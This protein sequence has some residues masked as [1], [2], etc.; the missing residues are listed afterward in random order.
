MQA[1]RIRKD[2]GDHGLKLEYLVLQQ[3]IL[4]F[5]FVSIFTLGALILLYAAPRG[6]YIQRLLNGVTLPISG[7]M[8]ARFILHMRGWNDKVIRGQAESRI[9]AP[10]AFTH[11]VPAAGE[12]GDT[13]GSERS[14]VSVLDEFGQDPVIEAR[15]LRRIF[16]IEEE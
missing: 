9:S 14:T 3:G 10:I 4:Y 12:E 15:L 1:W 6:S 2:L 13:D 16:T 8:V 11:S 5:C 7:L